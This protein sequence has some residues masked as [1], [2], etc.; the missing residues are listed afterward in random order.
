MD[1]ETRKTIE[2]YDMT[3]KQYYENVK[4]KKTSLKILDEFSQLL[5]NGSKVL[6][7]G[8][9]PGIHVKK[10]YEKGFDVVGT[11]LSEKMIEMA[12]KRVPDAEFHVMDIKDLRFDNEVFDAV[13]MN[14]TLIHVKKSNMPM[15]LWG[16]SRILKPGGL[17]FLGLKMGKGECM[18]KDERYGGEEKYLAYYEKDEI[19]EMLEDNGFDII[20]IEI[21]D[22]KTSYDTHPKIKLVCRKQDI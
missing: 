21:H 3:A 7:A 5:P 11:D 22:K 13:W 6:D 1:N 12:K 14:F 9:G 10:F 17:L 8:C 2:S 15:A 19:A 16:I 20:K 18:I 4:D